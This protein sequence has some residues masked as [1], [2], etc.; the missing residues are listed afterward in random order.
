MSKY[1]NH[2]DA[3]CAAKFNCIT[4]MPLY[5]IITIDWGGFGFW[6]IPYKTILKIVIFKIAHL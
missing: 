1:I 4:L 6:K 5:N 3:M 2:T